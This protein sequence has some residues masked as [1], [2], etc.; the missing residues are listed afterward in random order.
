MQ[1]FSYQHIRVPRG[2]TRSIAEDLSARRDVWG[3]F[4]GLFGLASDELILIASSTAAVAEQPGVQQLIH[5]PMDATARPLDA[6]PC[7]EPG[8]YVLRRFMVREADV[9][10]FVSLSQAAWVTFETDADFATR[11]MGLFRPA[12]NREGVVAMLL[13]TWYDGFPSWSTSRSPAADAAENF[14]RRRELTQST[15]A[16]ATQLVTQ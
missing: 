11:P 2:R 7:R 8:L 4:T 5:E 6:T 9:D 14:Q 16:L 1:H 10:E 13:V 15:V 12:V 3:V